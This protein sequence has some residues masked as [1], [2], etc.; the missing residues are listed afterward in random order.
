MFADKILNMNK[1]ETKFNAHWC[2]LLICAAL[3][4]C[5][6]FQRW[7]FA[8]I[9]K[10]RHSGTTTYEESN[11]GVYMSPGSSTLIDGCFDFGAFGMN[12]QRDGSI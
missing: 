3:F 6:Y 2:Y 4:V 12:E 1:S 7:E 9:F 10:S 11:S 5:M 8:I